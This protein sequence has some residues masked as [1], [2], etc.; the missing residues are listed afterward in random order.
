MALPG[1]LPV[2][3]K[4]AV[5]MVFK[6]PRRERSEQTDRILRD[7]SVE[8]WSDLIKKLNKQKACPDGLPTEL[9][10]WLRP[11]ASEAAR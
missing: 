9:Y 6:V 4:G 2:V 8:E 10:K 1:T 11:K 5:E 7:I 3:N